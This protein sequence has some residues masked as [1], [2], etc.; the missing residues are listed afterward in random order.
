LW[1]AFA[2]YWLLDLSVKVPTR[3]PSACVT[4]ALILI[5]FSSQLN[6]EKRPRVHLQSLSSIGPIF[7]KIFEVVEGWAPV[8]GGEED[9]R[10]PPILDSAQ[11]PPWSKTP[12][13]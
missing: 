6:T 9:R 12:L 1:I 2:G 4:V 8:E 13:A 7:V 11:R 3:H 10:H 5:S